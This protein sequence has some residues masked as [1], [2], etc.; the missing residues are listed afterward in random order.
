MQKFKR[1]FKKYFSLVLILAVGVIFWGASGLFYYYFSSPSEE[2]VKYFE[3]YEPYK[4]TA[5][6]YRNRPPMTEKILSLKE[7]TARVPILVYHTIKPYEFASSK[8]DYAFNVPP[9]TFEKQMKYLKNKKYN[10]ISM[11]MLDN[12]FE[13]GT[14]LPKNPVVITFDDGW[15]TQYTR[16]LPILKKYGFAATFYIIT[17][18]I[19]EK[20]FLNWEQVRNLAGA[21]MEIGGHTKSHPF[22]TDVDDDKLT[23]EVGEGKEIIE[24]NIGQAINTF[25]YPYGR[26][27]DRVVSA[28]SSAG[29]KIARTTDA[30][31]EQSLAE[32]FVLRGDLIFNNM[33]GLE[34]AVGK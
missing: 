29:Y 17:G 24:K 5:A 16:A 22:L 28:V 12:F 10:S 3:N 6:T 13:K 14:S 27:D 32:I 34:K 8:K 15:E 23:E 18:D 7:K 31:S 4:E 11:A 33:D 1:V 25:A 20:N 19:G 21:G 30:G 26:Y 2:F 9:R